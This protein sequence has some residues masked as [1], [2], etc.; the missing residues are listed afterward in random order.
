MNVELRQMCAR[1]RMC[2]PMQPVQQ[3]A[4]VWEKSGWC[5]VDAARSY[6]A[7]MQC[8][9]RRGRQVGTVVAVI[10]QRYKTVILSRGVG[11]V[12]MLV[13]AVWHCAGCCLMAMS[14]SWNVR[15]DDE[16]DSLDLPAADPDKTQDVNVHPAES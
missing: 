3:W 6:P 15:V 4:H 5:C 13:Y 9:A 7:V 2:S 10:S 8:A 1:A 11:F 14:R 12:L 16:R